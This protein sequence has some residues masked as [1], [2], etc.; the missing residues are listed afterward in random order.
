M[1][2]ITHIMAQAHALAAEQQLG[3]AGALNPSD[4]WQVLDSAADSCLIDVRCEA[5]WAF[6]GIVP[7]ALL[8]TWRIWPEMSVNPHFL[9]QLKQQVSP[10][11]ILLFICRSGARS[12]EAA[13]LASQ[14]G[15]G[16]CYNILEGFEGDKDKHGQRNRLNG[17]KARGLPWQQS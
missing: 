14:Q 1:A 13:M 17:W 12:H 11:E 7:G 6:V 5:E 15:Y 10:G 2:D 9:A 16:R 3:Y 4:A 8:I